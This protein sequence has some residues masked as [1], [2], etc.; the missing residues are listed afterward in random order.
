M[1]APFNSSQS[2][3]LGAVSIFRATAG[4]EAV[5]RAFSS[6][7][8][9]RSTRAALANLSDAQLADIG[10]TRHEIGTVSGALARR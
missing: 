2:V 4:I 5:V 9:A 1:S 10:V 3:P 6:W 7:N 8:R